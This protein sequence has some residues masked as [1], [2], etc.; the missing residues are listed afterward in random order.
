MATN[1]GEDMARTRRLLEQDPAAKWGFVVYRCTYERDDEWMRFLRYLNTRTRLRL[2]D[3]GDG[4][5]FERIDWQ[6][7]EDRERFD[8]AGPRELRR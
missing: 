8:R 1:V 6:V 3:Q 5:L 4:D 7:Q 2:E